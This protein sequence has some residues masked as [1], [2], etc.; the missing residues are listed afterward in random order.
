MGYVF[1]AMDKFGA[2]HELYEGG[3]KPYRSANVEGRRR[4]PSILHAR[5]WA[6]QHPIEPVE[7]QVDFYLSDP[8]DP[9]CA[10]F[11]AEPTRI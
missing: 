10:T 8:S 4:F 9:S 2:L 5:S 3:W 7:G 11:S 1:Y 6:L